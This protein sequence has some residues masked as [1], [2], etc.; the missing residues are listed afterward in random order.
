VNDGISTGG[1]TLC[2]HVLK[3]KYK[4]EVLSVLGKQ[5]LIDTTVHKWAQQ[6]L[7]TETVLKSK[8]LG[9]PSITAESPR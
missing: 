8:S 4:V 1:S 6:F 7:E 5:S 2:V 9:R 3:K